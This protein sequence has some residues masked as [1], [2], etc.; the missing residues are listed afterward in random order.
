VNDATRVEAE[1]CPCGQG[2]QFAFDSTSGGTENILAQES[3]S[4]DRS[5]IVPRGTYTVKAP[6][7]VTCSDVNFRV[8]DWSFTVENAK[9]AS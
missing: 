3:H 1:A 9:A 6:W 7:A 5:V 8:D 2:T 4:M